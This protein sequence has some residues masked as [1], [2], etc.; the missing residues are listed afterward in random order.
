[1]NEKKLTDK[2]EQDHI[3]FKDKIGSINDLISVWENRY[4]EELKKF[5]IKGKINIG[6]LRD[7][8]RNRIYVDD[9]PTFDGG[10]NMINLIAGGRS[11]L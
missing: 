3:Y 4:F 2:I 10:L 8:R 7:F 6:A 5:T 1:M 9:E 11:N